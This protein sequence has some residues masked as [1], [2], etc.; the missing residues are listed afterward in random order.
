MVACE[1]ALGPVRL[2]PNLGEISVLCLQMLHAKLQKVFPL[3]AEMLLFSVR[4]RMVGEN[5]VTYI[6]DTQ[7]KSPSPPSPIPQPRGSLEHHT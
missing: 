1:E 3:L 4:V 6:D 7:P 2:S 5:D